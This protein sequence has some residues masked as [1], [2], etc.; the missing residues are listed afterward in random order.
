M[1]R[2]SAISS[3]TS[4]V[5]IGLAEANLGDS[6]R[7]DSLIITNTDTTSIGVDLY[8]SNNAGVSVTVPILDGLL[9]RKGYTVDVFEKIPFEYDDSLAL[10]FKMTDA[11][12]TATATL[13]YT[14]LQPF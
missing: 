5:L 7:V 9:I 6:R 8:L 2:I 10:Y 13:C 12:Y 3:G 4:H 1:V 11:A 14:P